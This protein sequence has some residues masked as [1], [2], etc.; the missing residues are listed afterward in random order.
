MPQ[1]Y[2]ALRF[3]GG[4]YKVP[5]VIAAGLTVL[6]VLGFA[7]MTLGGAMFREVGRVGMMGGLVGGMLGGIALL[8]YGSFISVTLFAAS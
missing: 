1:R 3:I 5:A 2:A 4:L 8:V 7:T 6:G